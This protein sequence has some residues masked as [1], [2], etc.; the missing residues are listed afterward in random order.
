MKKFVGLLAVVFVFSLVGC[1][2]PSVKPVGSQKVVEKSSDKTPEWVMVPFFEDETTMY[3]SG[4]LKGVADY[5]VG[6][7]QAKA[8][9]MKNVA[10]SIE[11]KVRTE[12]VQNTR[13]AN[14][15][16]EDLGRFVQDG[17]A[18][19]SDN[20][21]VSGL[22]PAESYYE[23]VEEVTEMGVKY[24]YNCSVLFQL[25]VK[26]YKQARNRAING[27]VDKAK[28][29]QNKAAEKAAMGL[30]DKLQ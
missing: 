4:G 12:F 6:L 28:K 17:I 23:K 7:R 25:P 10:E 2:G 26:D 5:A 3:F 30:L 14:L 19:V 11:T 16:P 29:E 8:E 18:M 24:F 1:G 22:L 13:G 9:A 21:N 20:I 27:M 15:T